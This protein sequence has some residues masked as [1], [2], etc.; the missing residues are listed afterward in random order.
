MKKFLIVFS[1]V[2][3]ISLSSCEEWLDINYDPN[4][5]TSAS[6][7]LVLPGV[8]KGWADN[9]TGYA[10]T[11]GAW[12]GY[13]AHAGGWSGWVSEKSYTVGASYAGGT[14]NSF[15]TGPL[16]DLKYIMEQDD[17]KGLQ[18]NKAIATVAWA[19]Y[20]GRLV[21]MFGDVPY[22]EALNPTNTS[23]KYDDGQEIYNDLIVK[24]DEAMAVFQAAI[25][26]PLAPE[27]AFKK[28]ADIMYGGDFAKWT[29]FANTLK[30]RLLMRQTEVAGAGIAAKIA[31]TA[32]YGYITADASVN[33]G[34]DKV[35]GKMHPLW[36]SF[37]RSI[38]DV[39]TSARSQYVLNNFFS[40][41][42]NTLNDPRFTKYFQPGISAAGG[43]YR[44]IKFG[45]SDGSSSVH[46]NSSQAANIGWAVLQDVTNT[47]PTDLGYNRRAIIIPLSEAYLLQ[48]EAIQ[49]G[50]MAGDAKAMFEAG[51]T[52][53]CTWAQV[54]AADIAPYLTSGVN[55]ADW[56]ASANK[57]EAIIY[58]KYIAN[59]FLGHMEAWMDYRRTGYPDPLASDATNSMLTYYF[60][61]VRRQVP[62]LF[63]Y[64]QL[65][66]DINTDNVQAVITKY[67]VPVDNFYTFDARTFW[68]KN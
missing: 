14:M 54:P 66:F 32:S 37:G 67:G 40:N 50:Y 44:S 8:L 61:Y 38:T 46:L 41:L 52:A 33:P 62:R 5:A 53:S 36:N 34:F 20:Y 64:P 24:L 47:P 7:D 16:T 31:T 57:I 49:R 63:P 58:Q 9:A 48:A 12:M 11:F 23:P 65:E 25:A 45:E 59:Y 51:V 22:T 68:D 17:L 26:S 2:L 30:L 29:R 43:A 10:T 55:R 60:T 21:D 3:L 4:N 18:V 27:Y 6:A 56:D 39:E 28:S 42:M 13:W 19:W 35:A 15:Y 1:S